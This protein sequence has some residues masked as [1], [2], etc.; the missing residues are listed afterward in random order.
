MKLLILLLPFL[1]MACASTSYKNNQEPRKPASTENS[2]LVTL[3]K[4]L[5]SSA[6]NCQFNATETSFI[7]GQDPNTAEKVQALTVTVSGSTR[8]VTI[9][10]FGEPTVLYTKYFST[11]DKRDKYTQI[12][13]GYYL[14]SDLSEI[15]GEFSM[16][17]TDEGKIR[18]FKIFKVSGSLDGKGPQRSSYEPC[19]FQ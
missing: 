13:R 12:F 3:G 14:E 1:L 15:P 9:T 6:S 19:K 7:F 5:S 17:Y 10:L 8:P 11:S 2:N 4:I 18:N 16:E